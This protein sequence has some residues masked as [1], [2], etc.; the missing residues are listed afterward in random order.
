MALGRADA[1]AKMANIEMMDIQL[2]NESELELDDAGTDNFPM[3]AA[4]IAT[5]A[6]SLL[7]PAYQVC[8]HPVSAAIERELKDL[9]FI[10]SNLNRDLSGLQD[11]AFRSA[12]SRTLT[13]RISGVLGWFWAAYCVMR[14]LSAVINVASPKSIRGAD[15]VTIWLSRLTSLD[16]GDRNEIAKAASFAVLG[17]VMIS[18]ARSIVQW[19]TK[20]FPS[21]LVPYMTFIVTNCSPLKILRHFP[22]ITQPSAAFS[23][24]LSSHFLSLYALSLIT[25]L[26][27]PSMKIEVPWTISSAFDKINNGTFLVTAIAALGFCTWDFRERKDLVSSSK[28]LDQAWVAEELQDIV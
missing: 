3:T 9:D 24:L 26:Q 14:L 8:T 7:P 10:V 27:V 1:T 25:M 4:A 13:G 28:T 20:V 17:G 16:E 22:S 19:G 23:T 6:P 15:P 2:D 5:T 18:S 21:M 12:Y 11:E